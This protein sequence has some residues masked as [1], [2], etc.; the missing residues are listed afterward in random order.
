MLVD[1]LLLRA[2]A[3]EH[4]RLG[5]RMRRARAAQLA[6]REAPRVRRATARPWEV[7]SWHAALTAFARQAHRT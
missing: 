6:G 3:A 7:S 2:I 1:E 5:E 4:A